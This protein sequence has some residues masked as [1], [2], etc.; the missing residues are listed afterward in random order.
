VAL[1]GL[2]LTRGAFAFLHPYAII[3]RTPLIRNLIS[4]RFEVL[5]WFG[6]IVVVAVGTNCLADVFA[7]HRDRIVAIAVVS[8]VAYCLPLWAVAEGHS[9]H[10]SAASFDPALS[11][12]QSSHQTLTVLP[13]PYFENGRSMVQSATQGFAY[14]L[15]SGWGPTGNHMTPPEEAAK[16]AISALVIY[17]ATSNPRAPYPLDTLALID[18]ELRMWGVDE[19]VAPKHFTTTLD[20]GYT[21]PNR[22][23]ALF[24]Q[25]YGRPATLDGEWV[26]RIPPPGVTLTL[27]TPRQW[28]QCTR[29]SVPPGS[30]PGC[31]LSQGR[32]SQ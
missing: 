6:V 4:V 2:W 32:S 12:V 29:G 19:I 8:V 27:L 18:R 21:Q 7:R 31:V 17:G 30:I 1:V 13:Y 16:K 23:V 24:T 25:I 26:W 5:M 3:W 14:R 28:A 10:I 22:F 11:S 9:F 15:L 20:A